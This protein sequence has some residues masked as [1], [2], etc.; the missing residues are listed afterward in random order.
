MA[1]ALRLAAHRSPALRDPTRWENR[2]PGSSCRPSRGVAAPCDVRFSARSAVATLA[3]QRT[4]KLGSERVARR[5]SAA[6]VG[7]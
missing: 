5:S 6:G 7:F 4:V 1:Y 3:M 2:T